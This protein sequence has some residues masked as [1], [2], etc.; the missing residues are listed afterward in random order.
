M[1]SL[2]ARGP[3]ERNVIV[4]TSRSAR[5][6]DSP[7]ARQLAKFCVQKCRYAEVVE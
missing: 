7:G 2:P 4:A 1:L 3:W 6:P 5:H